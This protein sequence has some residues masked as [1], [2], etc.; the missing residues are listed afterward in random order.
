MMQKLVSALLYVWRVFLRFP[1]PSFLLRD[2]PPRQ[3]PEYTGCVMPLAGALAGILLWCIAALLHA[4][5]GAP[6]SAL[7]AGL[8]CAFLAE[9]ALRWQGLGSVVQ[10]LEL[11]KSGA[12]TAGSLDLHADDFRIRNDG[13]LQITALFVWLLRA[14]LFGLLVLYGSAWWIIPALSGG[15]FVQ[16]GLSELSSERTGRPFFPVAHDYPAGHFIAFGAVSLFAGLLGMNLFR[17]ICGFLAAWGLLYAFRML[18]IR[19]CQAGI[20][21]EHLIFCGYAAETVLLAAGLLFR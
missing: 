3:V 21:R 15:L 2:D 20:R 6:A 19:S 7:I 17:T 5:F 11:K 12:S 10:F 8:V 4:L 1:I 14:S 16:A 13:A 9:L 18:L